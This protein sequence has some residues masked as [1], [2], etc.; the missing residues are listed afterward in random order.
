MEVEIRNWRTMTMKKVGARIFPNTIYSPM[1]GAME[2]SPPIDV[3]DA[4][5]FLS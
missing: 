1:K 3:V 2:K 5:A 4:I